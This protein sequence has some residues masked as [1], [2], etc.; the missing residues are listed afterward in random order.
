MAIISAAT[1]AAAFPCPG[2][3]VVFKRKLTHLDSDT[4]WFTGRRS[5]GCMGRRLSAK[6]IRLRSHSAGDP[7]HEFHPA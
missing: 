1:A 7:F 4:A 5:Q 3:K 2:K 6:R